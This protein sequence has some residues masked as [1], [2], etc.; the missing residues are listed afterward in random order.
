MTASAAAL[1]SCGETQVVTETKTQKVI[2]E[3]SVEKVVT[4]IVEVEKKIVE[5]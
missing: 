4:R 3:A 1:A 5:K 2:K